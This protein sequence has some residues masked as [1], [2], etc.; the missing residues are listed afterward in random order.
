M[1]CDAFFEF[2]AVVSFL[3]LRGTSNAEIERMLSETYGVAAPSR[4]FVIKWAWRFR[5]GRK[6]LEDD[7]STGRLR[8]TSGLAAAIAERLEEQPFEST[9]SLADA[10]GFSHETIRHAL[11]EELRLK[12]FMLWWVPNT[13]SPAQKQQRVICAQ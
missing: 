4:P 7:P 11:R 10:L 1:S 12:K 6:S 13:L 3:V 8:A 2:R 9:H 5:A